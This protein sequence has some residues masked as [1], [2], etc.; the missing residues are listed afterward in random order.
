M[1]PDRAQ[2]PEDLQIRLALYDAMLWECRLAIGLSLL[3]LAISLGSM[4]L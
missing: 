1:K 2:L 3:A 4:F